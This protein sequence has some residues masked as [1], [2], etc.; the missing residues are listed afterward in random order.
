[1]STLST[2]TTYSSSC[3]KTLSKSA[4]V[5]LVHSSPKPKKY[6]GKAAVIGRLADKKELKLVLDLEA[7]DRW[8]QLDTESKYQLMNNLRIQGVRLNVHRKARQVLQC[9]M[10]KS[11]AK[12][13]ALAYSI[14]N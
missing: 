13:L 14:Q 10:N 3:R 5:N 1:M 7:F 6:P 12:R 9:S 11:E 4:C 2:S 8:Y